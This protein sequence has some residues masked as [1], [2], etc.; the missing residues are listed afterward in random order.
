MVVFSFVSGVSVGKLFLG[1]VVP[2]L[3]V[4][5]ALMVWVAVQSK[6][7][8]YPR[9]P[10]RTAA[11]AKEAFAEAVRKAAAGKTALCLRH[12]YWDHGADAQADLAAYSQKLIDFFGRKGL[13]IQTSTPTAAEARKLGADLHRILAR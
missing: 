9:Q 11:A 7:H 2:G 8:N 13:F 12:Y 5:A 1:G 3:A 4:T 6:K 10:F